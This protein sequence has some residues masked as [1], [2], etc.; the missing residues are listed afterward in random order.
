MYVN[1]DDSAIVKQ[2]KETIL[3]NIK[4]QFPIHETH[5][6]GALLDPTLQNVRGVAEY[7]TDKQQSPEEF[8]KYMIYKM[9]PSTIAEQ[10]R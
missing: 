2:L 8:L 9:I 10:V 6:C 3:Q 4:K 5:V 7:L 1:E